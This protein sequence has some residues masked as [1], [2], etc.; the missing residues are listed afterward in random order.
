MSES[1]GDVLV[2]KQKYNLHN[3]PEVSAAAKRTQMHTGERVP[4]DPASS[5]ENYLNRFQEILD[6]PDQDKRKRGIEALKKVLHSKFVVK[7][8]EIPEAYWENQ[9]RLVRER[10]QGGDLEQTDWQTIKDQN[11]EAII[12]DQRRS[13]DNWVDYLASDDAKYPKWL[14]YWTMRSIVDMSRFDKEKKAFPKRSQGTTNPFPEIDR[15]ALAH[16]LDLVQKKYQG[17]EIKPPFELVGDEQVK[18]NQLL[19]SESFPKLYAWTIEKV[20]PA[21][22]EQLAIT[23]GK[24][25][26]YNQNSDHLPLVQSLQG[27][28]TGWCTAGES[29]AQI[30]LQGGDFYVFY[31]KS[32]GGQATIPRVA[33]RMESDHIAEVRGIAKEQNLDPY[34]GN[35]VQE[36]LH[37]FPDGATYEKKVADMKLLTTIESKTKLGGKLSSAELIFLYEMETPIQGFGYQKD[38]RIAELRSTRNVEEDM[39]I[40]FE[41]SKEQIAHERGEIG[42]NTKAFVGKLTPGIF[43]RLPVELQHIYTAF[44]EKRIVRDAVTIGVT[45]TKALQEKI[46]VANMQVSGWAQEL[47]D[48]KQFITAKYAEEINLVKLQVSDLGFTDYPTTTEVYQKAHELGLELCPAEVGPQYRLKYADQPLN[49]WAYVGMEQ[50]TDSGAYPSVFGLDHGDDGLWLHASLAKPGGNWSLDDQFIF[51]HRKSNP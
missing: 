23:E 10:G 39:P 11:S 35:V 25:V 24:W 21:S 50:I 47:L 13:L 48:S 42:Q 5:I 27:H 4:Q 40:V 17:G 36:K 43:D 26:K 32:Q 31:S 49:E 51:R 6:R 1:T 20:T 38:P 9:K 37:E 12:A 14:K 15:E 19:K 28:G 30:Q 46:R 18:F 7:A 34:I 22:V 41:C 45:S 8:D 2:L 44:P 33:I 29:T 16:V 3:A